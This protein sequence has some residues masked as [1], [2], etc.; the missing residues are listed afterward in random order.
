MLRIA[1]TCQLYVR[2]SVE[3]DRLGIQQPM[4]VIQGFEPLVS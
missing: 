2:C 3:A 4:P 1:A